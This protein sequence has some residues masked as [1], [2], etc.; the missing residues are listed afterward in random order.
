M[1][2]AV[3]VDDQDQVWLTDF[4]GNALLRFDPEKETFETIPLPSAGA[5]VRQLLG[6]PGEVW[7]AESGSDKLVVVRTNRKVSKGENLPFAAMIGTNRLGKERNVPIGRTF[8]FFFCLFA[9]KITIPGIEISLDLPPQVELLDGDASFKGDLD[10]AYPDREACID[11]DLKSKTEM[12]QW[13]QSI[14]ARMEFSHEGTVYTR[15]VR[16]NHQ[17]MKDTLFVPKSE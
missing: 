8:G 15:E 2:Y 12:A 3:F 16:W 6:R 17:G 7:G 5:N 4:G 13:S 11:V 1:I 14:S 9:P 10:A